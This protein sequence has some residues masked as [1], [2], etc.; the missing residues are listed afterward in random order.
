VPLR[1]IRRDVVAKTLARDVVV[2]E[3]ARVAA[4][5]HADSAT[6]R[7]AEVVHVVEDANQLL[8]RQLVRRAEGLDRRCFRPRA[9]I[10]R[11][12]VLAQRERARRRVVLARDQ[13][14]DG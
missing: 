8:G 3:R 7:H 1:G 4:N 14:C 5:E 13:R 6:E 12:E 9:V 11:V 10:D 2:Q